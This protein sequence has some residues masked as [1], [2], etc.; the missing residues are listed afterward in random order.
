MSQ[1]NV[2]LVRR[3]VEAF[4]RRDFAALADYSDEELEFVSVIAAVDGE[5]AEFRGREIWVNYFAVMDEMW[6]GWHVADLQVWDAGDD[7]VAAILRMRGTGKQSGAPIQQ[8]VGIAY[9]IRAGKLW[10]MRSYSDPSEALEAVGLR[11]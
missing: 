10:R 6:D 7:Q 2:E 4:N 3:A 11:E 5:A 9:R 1:E 8:E